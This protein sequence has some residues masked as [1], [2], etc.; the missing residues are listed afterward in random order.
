MIFFE[1]LSKI[2]ISLKINQHT[3]SWILLITFLCFAGST[4]PRCKNMTKLS[5]WESKIYCLLYGRK[6]ESVG[7]SGGR[8]KLVWS[9]L[10][11]HKLINSTF[12]AVHTFAS[13]NYR[14]ALEP[15]FAV[16]PSWKMAFKFMYRAS[17]HLMDLRLTVLQ[18]TLFSQNLKSLSFTDV[19]CSLRCFLAQ[20][21]EIFMYL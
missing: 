14:L 3:W 21:N 8:F 7:S 17:L 1:K 18:I 12:A 19:P 13:L 15:F 9:H 4:T 10:W 11:N 6:G 20:L 16:R 5:R 2:W